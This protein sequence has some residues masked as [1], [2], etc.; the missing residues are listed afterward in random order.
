[1][2]VCNQVDVPRISTTT[3]PYNGWMYQEKN[4]TTTLGMK[5]V[6]SDRDRPLPIFTFTFEYENEIK[7]WKVGNKNKHELTGYH[8]VSKTN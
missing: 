2:D 7:T 6:R 1:M 4:T 3:P 5:A 8:D